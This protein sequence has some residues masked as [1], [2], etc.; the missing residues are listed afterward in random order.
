MA[1]GNKVRKVRGVEI[2]LRMGILY[3]DVLEA[4][5]KS[6][7]PSISLEEVKSH[8]QGKE[9]EE[10]RGAISTLG[11]K[12]WVI[13][14]PPNSGRYTLTGPGKIVCKELPNITIMQRFKSHSNPK[15]SAPPSP[16][17][18]PE[19]AQINISS[20]ANTL[21]DTITDVIEENAEYRAL[22]LKLHKTIETALGL[23]TETEE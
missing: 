2:P 14:S 23:N 21:A 17:P 19:P 9:Q 18:Q 16:K 13:G 10:V 20:K 4:F 12:G 1:T 5:G 8:F 15:K 22:L 11:K 6:T 3:K 7:E